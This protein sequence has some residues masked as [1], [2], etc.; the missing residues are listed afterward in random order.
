MR[1]GIHR[2]ARTITRRGAIAGLGAL[3]ALSLRAQKKRTGPMPRATPSICLFSDVL[4]IDYNDMGGF[5]Q[6]MGFD[7][8][9]LTVQPGG[10]IP[11]EGDI[12]L[13]LERAVEAM[14]GS[15]IDVPVLS[16]SVTSVQSKELRT[17]LGWGSEMGVPIFSP[18]QWPN[19]GDGMASVIMAQREISMLAQIGHAAK[20]QIALHNATPNFVGSSVAELNAA[21]RPFDAVVGFNFDAGYAAAYSG[22]APGGASAGAGDAAAVAAAK[23]AWLSALKLAVPRLKMA[24]ARDC[25]WA[26][27]ADGSQTL[28][29]CPLGEGMVDWPQ[30]FGVLAKANFT[31]PITLQVDYAPKDELAAVRKDLAFLK[32]QRAAAYGG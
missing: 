2:G 21:I 30:F 25:K 6:M 15:G 4:K 5:L 19:N 29:Q 27:G 11:L 22:P 24:T 28:T 12:D 14:T 18:G 31:G 17:I 13:H 7:G 16:T 1:A 3:G 32:K 26:K 8:V 23:D 9:E 10:H 20:M